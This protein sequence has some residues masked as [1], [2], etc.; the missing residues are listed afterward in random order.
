MICLAK[1]AENTAEFLRF[2]NM[3]LLFRGNGGIITVG[4]FGQRILSA[5]AELRFCNERERK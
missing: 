2:W 1:S 3:L 5:F 4:K